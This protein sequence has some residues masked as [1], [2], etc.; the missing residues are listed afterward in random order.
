MGKTR[1]RSQPEEK[2]QTTSDPMLGLS[3]VHSTLDLYKKQLLSGPRLDLMSDSLLGNLNG[4]LCKKYAKARYGSSARS[5]SLKDLTSEM[6]VDA[7][8]RTLFGNRI[9]G[10]E[11]NLVR[12]L[13]DFNDDTWM[14]VFKYPQSAASKPYVARDSVLKGF[15]AYVQSPAEVHSGQAWLI[16]NVLSRQKSLDICDEDRAALLLMIYWA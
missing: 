11:P 15:T 6:L 14:L 16:E 13:L 9:Y 5:V 1:D 2:M 7:I 12:N 3:A 8:T 10:C 4:S